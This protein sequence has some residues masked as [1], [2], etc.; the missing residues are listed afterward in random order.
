MRI[1][2]KNWYNKFYFKLEMTKEIII[3]SKQ[4]LL[5]FSNALI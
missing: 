1:F 3:V 5:L 2:Y 4:L